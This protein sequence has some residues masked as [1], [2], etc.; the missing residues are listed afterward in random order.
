MTQ[1]AE[2]PPTM[3][4]SQSMVIRL[5]ARLSQGNRVKAGKL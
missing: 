2:P 1:P 3:M 4:I 5:V